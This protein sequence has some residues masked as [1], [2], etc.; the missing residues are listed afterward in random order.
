MSET[1]IIHESLPSGRSPDLHVAACYVQVDNKLLFLR[2]A[3]GKPEEDLWGV[4]AGKVN[5][6]EEVRDAA[7]RELLEETG[8][9]APNSRLLKRK[10]L[11]IEKPGC[12][13][14]YH[15]FSLALEKMPEIRLALE[16]NE[17]FAW[18]TLEEALQK[19]LMG[20][21]AK[22]LQSFIRE[23]KASPSLKANVN[24]YLILR[25]QDEVLLYFRKNTG[26]LD[27][28]HGLVAGHVE[29]GE[30]ALQ[31]IIREAW[32]ES[33]IMLLPQDLRCM[34]VM[35]RQSDRANVDVFFECFSWKGAIVNK[36]P[37][38]CGELKF[39]PIQELPD[40]IIDYVAYVLKNA[41]K[42]FYSEFGWQSRV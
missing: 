19:P 25:R 24:A 34:H 1:L 11:F 12:C 22:A 17:A 10:T 21:A 30:S 33:G 5:P 39:Y 23:T 4:P 18:M 35:H 8:I 20:G 2:R 7:A 27:G 9:T 29:A 42:V 40:T 13:Y 3:R 28:Q 41:G 31:A 37:E 38:K 14:G 26:Y 16:E 6:G 36:E 32:E 15:M